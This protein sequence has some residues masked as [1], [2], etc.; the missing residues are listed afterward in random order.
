MKEIRSTSLLPSRCIL[1]T[2]TQECFRRMM[3]VILVD[4][5][6]VWVHI[7]GVDLATAETFV[8]RSA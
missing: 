8:S 2:P 5:D 6:S 4:K 1:H 7:D 3:E